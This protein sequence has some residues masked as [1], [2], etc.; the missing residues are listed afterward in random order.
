MVEPIKIKLKDSGDVE[1]CCTLASLL[2]VSASPKP[3]N[4]H[5]LTKPDQYNSR[6]EQFLAAIASL[7]KVYRDVANESAALVAESGTVEGLHLGTYLKEGMVQMSGAQEGGNL[8]LGHVLL[9]V[10]LAAATGAILAEQSTPTL[11]ALKNRLGKVLSSGSTEDV[12]LM[13]EGM[14]ACNPGGLGTTNEYDINSDEFRDELRRGKVTFLDVFKVKANSDLI[15]HEWTST[16][17][18]TF[19]EIFPYLKELID[20]GV[21]INDATVQCFLEILSIYPD[22]LIRRKNG[23]QV[24]L[25]VT[26]QAGDVM[27]AGGM[28]TEEGIKK[29]V[30]FD[31]QLRRERGKLNPGTTADLVAAGIF[32]LLATGYKF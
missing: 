17:D 3:G 13:Y 5:R 28:V 2:E 4:I 20:A 23:L 21:D 12:I 16:F 8:L 25:D 11:N 6:Y 22:S 30:E 14:R 27:D 1:R 26:R 18:I 10:P 29:V 19:T 9:L 7:A 32:L 15:C 24:A 31:E